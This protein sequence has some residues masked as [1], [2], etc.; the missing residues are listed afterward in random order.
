MKKQ[1]SI[2]LVLFIAACSSVTNNNSQTFNVTFINWNGDLLYE[3]FVKYGETAYYNGPE[4]TKPSVG[5]ISY[6]FD[7]WDKDLTN[8]N[9]DFTTMAIFAAIEDKNSPEYTNAKLN[10]V[11]A[12]G[13]YD[14][15]G[16]YE[17]KESTLIFP[18]MY[19]GLAVISIDGSRDERTT[20][21]ELFSSTCGS[22][23][24]YIK[25]PRFLR[26]IGYKSFYKYKNPIPL[27]ELNFPENLEE[28][29]PW[30]FRSIS[31]VQ[32]IKFNK[33]LKTI[34][35]DA[36]NETFSNNISISIYI[37]N[38]VSYIGPT[39]FANTK[40]SKDDWHSL[41]IDLTF[42]CEAESQPSGWDSKWNWY[43]NFHYN[44]EPE[45][46]YNVVWGVSFPY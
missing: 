21:D 30:A 32:S 40:P 37:P 14:I 26:K 4:P 31:N 15:K 22:N 25:F 2:L 33:G 9:H 34:G 8:V 29:D 5:Y 13:G 39:A 12:K 23:I 20:T 42:Y 11:E 7:R 35:H 19:D 27:V 16:V 41:P 38:S 18:D 1:I 3:D 10:I 36:F 17:C 43:E 28:I 24:N 46:S 6:V 45:P 44:N